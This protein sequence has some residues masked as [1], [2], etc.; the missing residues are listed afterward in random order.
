MPAPCSANDPELPC[1]LAT[2]E[3]PTERKTNNTFYTAQEANSAGRSIHPIV[4]NVPMFL[5]RS[6]QFCSRPHAAA[7]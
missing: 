5:V 1:G 3:A 6:E 4:L 2:V 7:P